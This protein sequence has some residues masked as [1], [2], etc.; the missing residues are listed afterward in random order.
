MNSQR[1][2]IQKISIA[3]FRG[4]TELRVIAVEGKHLFLLGPNAFGKS[5][6]VEAIRWCLF[7]SPPGQQDIEVRNTFY[8]SKASEVILDLVAQNKAI[9]V[10]RYLNPGRTESRRVITDGDGKEIKFNDTFPQIARLGSPTGT[11]V[12]FAAQHASGRPPVEIQD[13]SKVLYFY[14]GIE[15]IPE[16]LEK[17]RKLTEERRAERDDMAK[18]LDAF[19]QELRNKL[20]NIQGKKEE[21]TKNPPWGKGSIPTRA[22]TERKID[23]MFH[24]MARLVDEKPTEGFTCHQKLQKIEEWSE[25]LSSKEQVDLKTKL[26]DL[27][28]KRDEAQRIKDACQGATEQIDSTKAQI[29]ELEK[30][31]HNLLM[32]QTLDALK[33]QLE[34]AK[35]AY[36]EGSL[37]LEILRLVATYWDKYHPTYCPACNATLATEI[38]ERIQNIDKDR[39]S[40][41]EELIRRVDEISKVRKEIEHHRQSLHSLES[42]YGESIR[43]AQ[44]ITGKTGATLNEVDQLIQELDS[45]IQVLHNQLENT[46]SERDGR[47]RRINDIKAEERFHYY[48]DQVAAIEKILSKDI[49]GPRN[50]LAEYDGFLTT[51]KMVGELMLDAFD[52]QTVSAIPP[53][54]K[55]LTQVYEQLT[56]HPSYD[57]VFIAKQTSSLEKMEPGRLELKVT[58]SKCPPG[59]L[60]PVNVL[61]GQAARALQLVPY[62]V[63]SDYWHDLMELDLLLVDDPSESFDTSHLE[64]LM[65]VLH[66]VASHTQL[67][68]ASHESDRMRPLIEEYFS[69]NERCIFAI[70]DFDPFKGPTLEQR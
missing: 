38:G 52:K 9:K 33:A 44:M 11:Q 62:F 19:A 41:L 6:V 8:P 5:T 45:D 34:E 4:T 13:F 26:G 58:S 35:K 40:E 10:R 50:A 43:D 59:R 46:R 63:F 69:E 3:N 67:V 57:G 28:K 54:A 21:I 60:F 27:R 36:D 56:A 64:N 37:R 30:N 51:L 18:S 55:E 49:E 7:G 47:N 20:T 25:I 1:Y 61:N 2:K 66:S 16:L 70:T 42:R 32:G 12:I 68:I 31:E 29:S 65:Q 24:E 22:E 53:L 39:C 14:L 23:T 17:L 15:E 48:Q